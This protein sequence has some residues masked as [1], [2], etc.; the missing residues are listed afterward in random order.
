MLDGDHL[1]IWI[2][3]ERVRVQAQIEV[4]AEIEAAVGR[5]RAVC[6]GD[7]DA[8]RDIG[9]PRARSLR[10][11]L[12][13]P[14][15]RS[16]VLEPWHTCRTAWRGRRYHRAES[17]AVSPP[18]RPGCRLRYTRGCQ[19]GRGGP[20]ATAP[21]VTVTSPPAASRGECARCGAPFAPNQRGGH[22]Q[23]YCSRRC[24]NL[25][26]KDRRKPKAA[27]D[28]PEPE[29]LEVLL[30][31]PM[32]VV[33]AVEVA[34]AP[35]RVKQERGYNHSLIA[36]KPPI[37]DEHRTRLAQQHD[38]DADRPFVEAVAPSLSPEAKARAEAVRVQAGD[39]AAPPT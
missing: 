33:E 31:V 8:V 29:P 39:P 5:Y 6:S 37:H 9:A 21:P 27:P 36:T 2:S 1:A 10:L 3:A 22:R 23:L 38:R 17:D 12:E 11:V 18:R 16:R 4:L 24:R 30:S 7:A 19:D 34:L 28:E 14:K 26:H 20:G 13:C 15:T 25:T 35:V 32:P